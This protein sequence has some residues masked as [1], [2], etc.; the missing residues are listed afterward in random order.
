M[1]VIINK[2]VYDTALMLLRFLNSKNIY[3]IFIEEAT[4]QLGLLSVTDVVR[5]LSL[6]SHFNKHECINQSLTWAVTK[7]KYAYWKTIDADWR[8]YLNCKNQVKTKYKSLW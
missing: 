6:K 1:T 7:Q 3:D 5:H 2:D 4:K 8:K